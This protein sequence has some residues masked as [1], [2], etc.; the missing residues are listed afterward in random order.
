MNYI[1]ALASLAPLVGRPPANRK[2]SG[3]IPGQVCGVFL[4]LSPFPLSNQ[5]LK[6]ISS[7]DDFLKKWT[8]FLTLNQIS[9]LTIWHELHS[10]KFES[11]FLVPCLGAGSPSDFQAHTGT[12]RGLPHPRHTCPKTN[13]QTRGAGQGGSGPSLS[14]CPEL[15]PFLAP[16]TLLPA[17][18]PPQ[19]G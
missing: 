7:G 14:R 6:N 3:S 10:H 13:G 1:S 9:V 16:L 4:S 5:F 15:Q 17:P 8:T 2:F 12:H 19:Q 18:T 11:L